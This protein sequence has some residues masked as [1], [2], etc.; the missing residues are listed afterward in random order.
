MAFSHFCFSDSEI[1]TA[2]TRGASSAWLRTQKSGLYLWLCDCIA[3]LACRPGCS[4]LI[5]I[6]FTWLNIIASC[7][8]ECAP[9]TH[10]MYFTSK[11]AE[12]SRAF[13]LSSAAETLQTALRVR[14]YVCVRLRLL[15]PSPFVLLE[16]RCYRSE[17]RVFVFKAAMS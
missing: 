8:N 15:P 1:G 9:H 11:L 7:I 17:P 10:E 4:V 6:F 13:T 2:E 12:A 14:A 16:P 3:K 5:T